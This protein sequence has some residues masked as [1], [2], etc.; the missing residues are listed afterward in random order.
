MEEVNM[1]GPCVYCEWGYSLLDA[2]GSIVVAAYEEDFDFFLIE[3]FELFY[4]EGPSWVAWEYA[5]VEVS[6]N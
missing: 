4:H 6:A 1:A 2:S 5:I 3:A